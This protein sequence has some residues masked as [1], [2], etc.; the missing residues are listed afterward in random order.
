MAWIIGTQSFPSFD[1]FHSHC[2]ISVIFQ[3]VSCQ[4]AFNV[5]KDS[6]EMWHPEPSAGGD[7]ALWSAIE[8]QFIWATRT[9]SVN[10]NVDD[11]MF[12]YFG[13]PK[14]FRAPGCTVIS[15]SRSQSISFY[16]D[17]TNFCNMWNVLEQVQGEHLEMEII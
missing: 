2:A 8:M 5:M 11:I 7:Y 3:E 14:N 13:D 17:K 16:D 6:I 9:T 1:S 10:K 12:E 4:E 15:K